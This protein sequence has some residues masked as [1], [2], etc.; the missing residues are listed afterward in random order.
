VPRKPKASQRLLTTARWPVGI[1]FTSWS[2]LWRTTP[3]RR[4]EL[5]GRW[6][7]D[8]PPDVT[9]LVSLAEVQRA[10]DGVGPFLRR[11]YRLLMREPRASAAEIIR[12]VQAD[13]NRAAPGALA[14]FTK[15]HGADGGLRIGDE[16]TVHMPGPWDG[17][18]RVV[19]VTPASFRFVTLEGHIEAGQIEWR[20]RED[21]S[22]LAFEIESWSRAGD[23]LS[24]V[25]HHRLRMAKEVQLHMWTSVLERVLRRY[26]GRREGPIDIE[27]RRFDGPSRC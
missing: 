13:P 25:L 4:R 22:R 14:H 21:G 3:I 20:A 7:A 10:E 2:Y 12:D 26:G 23:G 19:E 15:V 8:A 16:F 6:A 27:T 24:Y 18:I 5:E 1:V 17:P 9:E 11:R